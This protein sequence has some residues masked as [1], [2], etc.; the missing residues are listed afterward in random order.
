MMIDIIIAAI[1]GASV[2]FIVL[3]WVIRWRLKKRH[4]EWLRASHRNHDIEEI[5]VTE[6]ADG[7]PV[8]KTYYRCKRCGFR[9]QELN[10][11][12]QTRCLG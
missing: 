12:Q 6:Y 7:E 3:W 8:E 9:L 1:A 11:L 4:S 2:G 10:E 5:T